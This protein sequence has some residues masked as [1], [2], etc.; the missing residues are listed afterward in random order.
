[1]RNGFRFP[2]STIVFMGTQILVR[3]EGDP[4]RL[5][6]SIRQ[7]ISNLNPDQQASADVRDLDSWIRR[8]PEFA[9]GRLVS[10]LFGAFSA[11]ALGL[12]AVGLYSV[13]SYSV[14]QRSGEFGIRMELETDKAVVEVPSS[15]SGVVKEVQVK[16]GDKIKVGQVIFTLEGSAPAPP[17]TRPRTAPVEHVSGQHGA[18]LAFQAAIRAEGK[19]EEQALPPDQP[20]PSAPVF[21]MSDSFCLNCGVCSTAIR[22]LRREPYVSGLSIL[23]AV[24]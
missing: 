24:P 4:L 14:E 13:V 18:R 19:T 17:T 22:R 11:L 5:L 1:M 3:A 16:E 10:I 23:R 6:R 20:K 9:N 21:S 12:A 15:V 7:S 8:E 2:I